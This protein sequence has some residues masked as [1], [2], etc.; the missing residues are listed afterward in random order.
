MAVCSNHFEDFTIE[1]PSGENQSYAGLETAVKCIRRQISTAV[2]YLETRIRLHQGETSL[3]LKKLWQESGLGIL[4]LKAA[5]ASLATSG[6]S[7]VIGNTRLKDSE[8]RVMAC[9]RCR[10]GR[11]VKRICKEFVTAL[12]RHSF[13]V[14]KVV[15]FEEMLFTSFLRKPTCRN[16]ADI[17]EVQKRQASLRSVPNECLI[18]EWKEGISDLSQILPPLVA[19]LAL[20]LWEAAVQREIPVEH[21]KLIRQLCTDLGVDQHLPH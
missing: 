1:S 3:P 20:C 17:D 2:V 6:D 8:I 12:R 19:D 4:I 11:L 14:E 21:R 5:Y 13:S 18:E 16:S 15:F 9:Q 10:L 7:L